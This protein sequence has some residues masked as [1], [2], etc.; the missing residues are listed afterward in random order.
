M[1]SNL[2]IFHIFEYASIKLIIHLSCNISKNEPTIGDTFS[3]T[4][5]RTSNFYTAY[6]HY[7]TG[8]L[9]SLDVSSLWQIDRQSISLILK[10][11]KR[12]KGK[13]GLRQTKVRLFQTLTQ[14]LIASLA[15]EPAMSF[16]HRGTGRNLCVLQSIFLI[17]S[18][19]S[20]Q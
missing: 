3:S 19:T 11:T 17:I 10:P 12:V 14:S 1:N 6:S 4:L 2:E 13:K 18:L 15:S 20:S 9:S 7:G 8:G 16:F 5:L